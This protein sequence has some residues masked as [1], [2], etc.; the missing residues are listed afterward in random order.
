MEQWLQ[1]IIDQEFEGFEDAVRQP[2]VQQT[3]TSIDPRLPQPSL[4]TD[5]RIPA[6][7]PEHHLMSE[8]Q[9]M[10]GRGW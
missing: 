1:S 4:E 7:S 8:D 10:Q 6:P 5:P 3:S 9:I 2:V